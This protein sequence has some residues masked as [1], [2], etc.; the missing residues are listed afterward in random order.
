MNDLNSIYMVGRLTNDPKTKDGQVSFTLA[1]N[2]YKYEE[3]TKDYIK[4]TCLFPIIVYGV[5]AE[6]MAKH[7]KKGLR[8]GVNGRLSI[9]NKTIQ[10]ISYTVQVLEGKK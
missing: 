5:E 1:N 3:S 8:V 9:Q 4:E 7:L 6:K 10:I 2:V